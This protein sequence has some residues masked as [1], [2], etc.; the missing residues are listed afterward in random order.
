MHNYR[1]NKFDLSNQIILIS[2]AGASEVKS[3]VA[4]LFEEG[5]WSAVR[6][7]GPICF[8]D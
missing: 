7:C 1:K 5:L 4:L 8:P 2:T 3:G 6:C